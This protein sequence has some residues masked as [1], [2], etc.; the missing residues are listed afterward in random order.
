VAEARGLRVSPS[1]AEICEAS[2]AQPLAIPRAATKLLGP[3]AVLCIEGE[4]GAPS[5]ARSNRYFAKLAAR[6]DTVV[7]IIG[8]QD[9]PRL[10]EFGGL[11]IRCQTDPMGIAYV[12]A[13]RAEALGIPVIDDAASILRCCNKVFAAERL[14]LAGIATPPTMIVGPTMKIAE[15]EAAFRYPIVLKGPDGSFSKSVVRAGNRETLSKHLDDLRQRSSVVI[16]QAYV[17][18][19]FDWRIAVLAGRPLFACQY[20]MARGHWQIIRHRDG[21]K[22][23]YGGV[24]CV[25]VADVPPA[26]IDTALAAGASMGDGLYG[27]D[28][29]QTDDGVLVIEVNDNPDLNHGIEDRAEGDQPW[30]DILTWFRL[31]QMRRLNT[32]ERLVP[33]D[34]ALTA[35][36]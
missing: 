16:A 36:G 8:P 35:A 13:K 15:I 31:A 9:L 6:H 34:R 17:A 21:G 26:I 27:V 19:D 2:H 10:A 20:R 32:A 1:V 12:F 23:L 28:L 14:A 29:K 18:T 30:R 11:W 25:A 7:E 4:A 33:P 22:S 5:D 3:L 24:K